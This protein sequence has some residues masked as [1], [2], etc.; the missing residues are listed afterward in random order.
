MPDYADAGRGKTFRILKG[1]SFLFNETMC[2]CG[3]RLAES[4]VLRLMGVGFRCA[5]DG[6]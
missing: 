2:Q 4:P 1:G 6:E 5:K 3:A